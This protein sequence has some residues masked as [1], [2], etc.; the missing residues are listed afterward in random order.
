MMRRAGE[1]R[2]MKRDL[3]G[4]YSAVVLILLVLFSSTACGRSIIKGKVVDLE[5]GKPIEKAAR[6][7]DWWKTKG[8]PGLSHSV[9]VETAETLSN[10]EGVFEIPV[11][12]T[13]SNEYT[14]AVYKSGYVCWSSKRIFPSNEKRKDSSLEDGMTIKLEP[15]TEKYSREKHA[16]F[17]TTAAGSST[18]VF[19]EATKPERQLQYDLIRKKSKKREGSK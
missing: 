12:S 19:S 9:N 7:I 11:Y 16:D 18:G 10:A 15:F 6:F 14:M 1:I 8:I 2:H 17:T 4:G 13:M 5:T 3:L